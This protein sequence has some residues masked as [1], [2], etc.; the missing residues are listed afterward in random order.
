[1]RPRRL[2]INLGCSIFELPIPS[3]DVAFPTPRRFRDMT[4][5]KLSEKR[6]KAFPLG[7]STVN[8]NVHMM[9]TKA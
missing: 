5:F 9:E 2:T 7:H 8:E 4:I 3:R 1:M 6:T